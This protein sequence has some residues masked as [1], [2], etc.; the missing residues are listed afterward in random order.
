MD[1]TE[2]NPFQLMQRVAE[3]LE[4]HHIPYRVVGSLASMAYGE[5]RFTNDVDM[6]VALTFDKIRV[7]CEAFT[8]PDYYLSENAMRE[9]I[10]RQSQFNLIHIPS[11]L[12]VDFIIARSDEYTRVEINRGKR[13]SVPDEFDA[14]FASP[15]D[16][17]LNKLIYYKEG[18]SEKHL[19]DIASMFKLKGDMLDIAY[20]EHWAETLCISSQWLML[21]DFLRNRTTN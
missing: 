11:G 19:R 15:E 8:L 17:I 9:A 1:G 12:K 21:Q 10:S 7:L 16:I 20:I 3:F 13:L 14:W 18:L 5:P 6:L 2:L 4:A